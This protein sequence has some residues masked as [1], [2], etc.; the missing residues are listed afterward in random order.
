MGEKSWNGTEINWMD[1]ITP[2][3]CGWIEIEKTVEKQPAKGCF[4][5]LL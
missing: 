2:E 4:C 5:I 1:G 3:L